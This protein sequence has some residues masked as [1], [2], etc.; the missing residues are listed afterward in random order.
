MRVNSRAASRI[1][2]AF[3]MYGDW[4]PT[5]EPCGQF[6]EECTCVCPFCG[7]RN[8]CTCCI[9]FGVATGGD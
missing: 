4:V 9:G 8:G 1:R 5:C 6:V 7:E 2:R 3:A